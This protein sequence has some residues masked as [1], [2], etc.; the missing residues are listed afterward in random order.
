MGADELTTWELFEEEFTL[1][2]AYF[3]AGQVCAE[4]RRSITGGAAG[5]AM[6]VPFFRPPEREQTAA[7]QQAIVRARLAAARRGNTS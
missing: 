1:P 6:F 4:L 2:D 7:E 3:V 5:A